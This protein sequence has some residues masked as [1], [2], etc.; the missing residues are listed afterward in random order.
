MHFDKNKNYQTKT[1][2]KF[3]VIMPTFN[4]AFCI[5]NAINSLLNQTYQD[6]ELIIIDDGSVDA[7]DVLIQNTYS[8]EIETGKIIYKKLNKNEGVCKARNFALKTAKNPWICYLDSDNLVMPYYLSDF[9]NAIICNSSCKTFYACS[10]KADALE[11][12]RHEYDYEALCS[13]NYIDLG[14]FCHHISLVKKYGNFDIK[15]RRL[16]DWDLILRYVRKNPPHFI[17]KILLEY[18]NDESYER[19]ST[20]EDFD[21]ARKYIQRKIE[22]MNLGFVKRIFSFKNLF[23]CGTWYRAIWF[24]GFRISIPNKQKAI[25]EGVRDRI[26]RLEEKFNKGISEALRDIED[27]QNKIAGSKNC[28]S[29]QFP[30]VFMDEDKMKDLKNDYKDIIPVVLSSDE[31]CAQHMYVA[32]LSVLENAL[33]TSYLDFYLLVTGSFPDY[34]KVYF[35]ELSTQ[36]KNFNINFVNMGTEFS[37]TFNMLEHITYPAYFRLKMPEILPKCYKKAIYIDVDL[38]VE[39]DL[40]E[41]FNI[42]LEDNFVAGVRAAGHLMY[43]D[44]EYEYYRE[45]GLCD[46]SKYICSG[47][48]LWNLEKIRDENMMPLLLEHSK[49]N[50]KIVDQDVINIVFYD[51]I[52]LLPLKYDFLTKYAPFDSSNLQYNYA[53]LVSIYGVKEIM[54]AVES[55]VIIHFAGKIKPWNDEKAYMADAWWKYAAKTPFYTNFLLGLAASKLKM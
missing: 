22:R 3:S 37:D 16:V 38:V 34:L 40:S 21:I 17:N 9:A 11:G 36:Y 2:P 35:Y 48:V 1:E 28:N 43:S 42:D 14:V 32:I 39:K 30:A 15:L 7:T 26:F 5:K 41:F 31:N 25:L 4:R 29:F 18:S 20:V 46:L 27:L 19:I 13:G 51:K 49:N 55:P 50:Y 53:K 54:E 23:S 47:V 12:D 44:D 8:K 52:K 33:S 45:N 24:L 6:F 10:K